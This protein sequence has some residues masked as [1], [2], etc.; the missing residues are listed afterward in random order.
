MSLSTANSPPMTPAQ[1]GLHPPHPRAG[2][3]GCRR[4]HHHQLRHHRPLPG[5]DDNDDGNGG[6]G[7]GRRQHQQQQQPRQPSKLV[8]FNTAPKYYYFGTRDAPCNLLP[9]QPF[10]YSHRLSQYMSS[11]SARMPGA[12]PSPAPAT[13]AHGVLAARRDV[14]D[15]CASKICQEV[16]DLLVRPQRALGGD[17]LAGGAKLK[18]KVYLLPPAVDEVI[19]CEKCGGY[20]LARLGIKCYIAPPP[21]PPQGGEPPTTTDLH[22]QD[23]FVCMEC[24][25]YIR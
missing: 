19:E 12:P 16:Y 21:P 3:P 2:M 8:R 5:D 7:A 10:Y 20:R 6:G 9:S 18:Y 4:R 22:Y 23:F 15:R 1:Q 11:V 17:P 13:T 14:I 24:N 25:R